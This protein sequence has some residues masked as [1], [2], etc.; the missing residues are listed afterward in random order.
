VHIVDLAQAHI[1]ALNKLEGDSAAYNLGNGD[2]YSVKQVIEAA[3]KITGHKIP[4]EEKPRRAG[5]PPRLVG[6][7]EKIRK[8]LGWKPKFPRI[9]EIV[10]SAWRWHKAHPKGYES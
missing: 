4:A 9:E 2:G 7:S 5:D 6:S 10:E 3:R 1:L 8:E